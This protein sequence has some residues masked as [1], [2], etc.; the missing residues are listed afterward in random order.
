MTPADE[1][2]WQGPKR[3]MASG[4]PTRRMTMSSTTKTK[5]KAANIAA[6]EAAKKRI[7]KLWKKTRGAGKW[8]A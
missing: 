3:R 7:A 2:P 4:K 6:D 8:T 1:A 5:P